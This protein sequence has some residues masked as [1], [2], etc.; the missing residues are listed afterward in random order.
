MTGSFHY[1]PSDDSPRPLDIKGEGEQGA[2]AFVG[3]EREGRGV[4]PH[5][6]PGCYNPLRA[7]VPGLQEQTVL[8][9]VCVIVVP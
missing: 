1:Y 3:I 6:T 7:L 5:G 9:T 2:V 8:H 4:D